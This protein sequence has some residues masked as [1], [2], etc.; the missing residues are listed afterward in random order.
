MKQGTPS[1]P[2]S[3]AES[4]SRSTSATSWSLVERVR[5]RPRV[6]AD[7]GRSLHEHGVVGQIGAFGEIE[8]H[9]LLFHLG[10]FADA[11][12]PADQPMRIERVGLPADLV[13][14]VGETLG[15]AAAD[16]RCAMPL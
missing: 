7:I 3:L 9:Q 12:C 10:G 2:A 13:D 1:M 8:I 5:G 15:A 4:A 6:E 11:V 16:T 14:G